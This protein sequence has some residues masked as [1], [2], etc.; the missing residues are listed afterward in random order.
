VGGKLH[1][2]VKDTCT[3]KA[4]EIILSA[5]DQFV[6]KIGSAT[7]TIKKSGDV[8]IKGSKVDVN[9]SGDITLKGSKL[10]EN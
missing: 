2:V 1:E 4:K 8:V 7:L 6:A 3:L 5:D 10:N 9:A